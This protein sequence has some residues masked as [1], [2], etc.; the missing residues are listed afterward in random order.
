MSRK[1]SSI[2]GIDEFSSPA[3]TGRFL[4]SFT[5][6]GYVKKSKELMQAFP[7]F[8]YKKDNKLLLPVIP[9]CVVM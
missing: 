5:A 9:T 6:L 2:W 8:P 7:R 3:N 4:D 1:S